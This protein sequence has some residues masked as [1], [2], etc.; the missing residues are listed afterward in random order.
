[1][2]TDERSPHT[3]L[4]EGNSVREPK[5]IGLALSG[6]GARAM[7]FHLGCLRA[8][9]DRGVLDQVRVLST[10]SGGSVIGAMYAYSDDTFEAFDA[11]V[12]AVLRRGLRGSLISRA[13]AP[14]HILRSLLTTA[15]ASVL[16]V[17]ADVVRTLAGGFSK[18]ARNLQ[19][20]LRRWHSRTT[21]FQ[22]SLDAHL[23]HGACVS[24]VKRASR[25]GKI[26]VLINATELRTGTAFRF[27]SSDVGS[28]RHGTLPAT[29]V[30]LS[31]GVAAS[32]AYPVFLPALDCEMELSKDGVTQRHRVLLTDGGVYDNLGTAPMEPGRDENVSVHVAKPDYIIA[33]DAGAGVVDGTSIPYWWFTRM[34]AAFET[35]FRRVQNDTRGRLH[36]H[37]SEGRVKGFLMP[38]LGQDDDRLPWKPPELVSRR[39]VVDYPTNFDPMSDDSIRLLATRGEQLTRV[40]LAQYMPDL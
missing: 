31:L 9:H 6:G 30:P 24:E 27:G 8:L 28:R 21:S 38:Y 16:A 5:Q 10:V 36:R 17:G 3:N 18:W 32:A 15:S 14:T 26:D 37:A 29:K 25:H 33:C 40:L 39:E 12:M 19:P 2:T 7:A 22:R 34:T 35:I 23:F 13:L 4:A 11:R 20:P 1:M